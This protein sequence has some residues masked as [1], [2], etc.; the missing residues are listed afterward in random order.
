MATFK[1]GSAQVKVQLYTT[2]EGLR[3]HEVDQQPAGLNDT[4]IWQTGSYSNKRAQS[5]D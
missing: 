1:Q 2:L 3:E 4:L 5:R